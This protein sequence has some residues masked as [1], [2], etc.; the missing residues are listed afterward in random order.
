[1]AFWF[2]GTGAP[3]A[4]VSFFLSSIRYASFLCGLWVEQG[5]WFAV[6]LLQADL[7]LSGQSA[8]RDREV[9][10]VRRPV[11]PD[12]LRNHQAGSFHLFAA[13]CPLRKGGVVDST[14]NGVTLIFILEE[15]VY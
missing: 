1:M 15:M 5:W 13:E 4:V 7:I 10:A 8:T 9:R 6:T 12:L 3:A 14:A 2:S 11:S